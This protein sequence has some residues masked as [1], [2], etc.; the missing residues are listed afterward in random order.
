[1][2]RVPLKTKVKVLIEVILFYIRKNIGLF[3]LGAGMF[4]IGYATK[5]LEVANLQRDAYKDQQAQRDL[6]KAEYAQHILDY[7]KGIQGQLAQRDRLEQE[8]GARLKE[9]TD[10]ITEQSRLIGTLQ[11]S[12]DRIEEHQNKNKNV[13]LGETKALVKQTAKA[14]AV[15]AAGSAAS[16]VAVA[17]DLDRKQINEEV[18]KSRGATK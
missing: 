18:R 2:E 9:Q 12:L 5:N 16:A 13:I 15:A 7:E 3:L 4:T 6:L 1:M 8:Q 11:A 10:R 14:A 17:P